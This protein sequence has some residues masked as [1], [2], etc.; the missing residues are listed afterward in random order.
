MVTYRYLTNPDQSS[1]STLY[2]RRAVE[3]DADVGQ[4][5]NQLAINETPLNSVRLFLLALLARRP[6]QKAWDNL[7]RT[8]EQKVDGQISCFAVSLPYIIMVSYSRTNLD[9]EGIRLVEAIK[10]LN[11]PLRDRHLA[12][13]LLILSL[14]T[15]LAVDSG[16][17]KVVCH[18]SCTYGGYVYVL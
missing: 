17:G 10:S 12:S 14:S 18:T 15:R 8:F 2:Y 16:N 7:K 3:M 6:F 11:D 4:A 5:F 9:S 1:L 13:L